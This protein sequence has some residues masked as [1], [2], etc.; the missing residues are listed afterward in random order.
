MDYKTRATELKKATR[1]YVR[2][3]GVDVDEVIISGEASR[4]LIEVYGDH[5]HKLIYQ[6]GVLVEYK[7]GEIK[8]AY[9]DQTHIETA[10]AEQFP[11]FLFI[12]LDI[13][14]PAPTLPME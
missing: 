2:K 5:S 13:I 8:D 11:P 14:Q 4:L 12:L 6:G 1:E 10:P 3:N 7:N 9:F